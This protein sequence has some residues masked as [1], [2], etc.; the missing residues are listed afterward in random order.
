MELLA[1]IGKVPVEEWLP[2]LVPVIALYLY[3]RRRERRRRQALTR[4]PAAD[5]A[6]DRATVEEVL[7][8]WS[9]AQHDELSAA[10]V[11]L[12]Y[13]PGPDGLNASELAARTGEDGASVQ[14]LLE[15]LEELGY[16]ELERRDDD[17]ER[18]AWL[19]FS[20][21]ALLEE[22]ELALVSRWDEEAAAARRS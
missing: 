15:E 5:R 16:V 3:G 18:R 19:T 9:R 2:F 11:R 17:D 20:G 14:A 13:P 12:F 10:H 1:H 6:L 8:R 7:A 4:L 21:Y 22:A